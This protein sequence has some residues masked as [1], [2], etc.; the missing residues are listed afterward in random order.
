MNK[1]RLACLGVALSAASFSTLALQGG[2]DAGEHFTH[3]QLGMGNDSPGVAL[4][5]EWMKSDHDGNFGNL[6][7]NYGIGSESWMISPGA[8]V[9]FTNPKDSHEGYAVAFG[10]DGLFALT[11]AIRL[12]GQYYWSPESMSAHSDGFHQASAGVSIRPIS[13]LDVRVGYK[14]V[15]INGKDGRKDNVLADG[16]YIGASLHF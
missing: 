8:K 2:V 9:L 7:L 10:G 13:L 5:G 4:S 11:S 3:L 15:A 6:G 1:L 16:P 12:Y 14:Y